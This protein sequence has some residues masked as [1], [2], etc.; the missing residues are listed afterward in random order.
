MSNHVKLLRDAGLVTDSRQGTR[1][2]LAVKADVA[3]E[4]LASLQHIRVAAKPK[5]LGSAD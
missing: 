1:R 3:D 5:E 4:L 2:K